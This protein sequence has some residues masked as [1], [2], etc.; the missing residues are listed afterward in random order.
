MKHLFLFLLLW[1]ERVDRQLHVASGHYNFSPVPTH[2]VYPAYILAPSRQLLTSSTLKWVDIHIIQSG[3]ITGDKVVTSGKTAVCRKKFGNRLE[4]GRTDLSGYCL[5]MGE[6]EK[7]Y[8]VLVDIYSMSRVG[9]NKWSMFNSPAVGSV[10][11][12]EKTF[13]GLMTAGEG[14]VISE[15]DYTRG[16]SGE[17]VW[18]MAEDAVKTETS[19]WALVETE[20]IRYSLEDLVFQTEKVVSSENVTLGT[21]HLERENS[22]LGESDWREVSERLEASWSGHELGQCGGRGAGPALHCSDQPGP[23]SP[24]DGSSDQ[25]PAEPG[26]A[27]DQEAAARHPGQCHR[28]R[29]QAQTGH[30]LHLRTAQRLHRRVLGCA[31]HHLSDDQG[32]VGEHHRE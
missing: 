19:G 4:P 1:L 15:L 12:N 24:Q 30:C 21:V 32:Q 13:V 17:F 20:P 26:E 25:S 7:D 23:E 6:K 2:G 18:Q 28:N 27:S 31:Q 8:Q 22:E 3:R 5:V 9:W 16:L 29:G 10:A 14:R 11:F